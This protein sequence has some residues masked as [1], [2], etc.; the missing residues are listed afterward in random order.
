MTQ[1][2]TA[3]IELRDLIL[4]TRIGTYGANDTVPDQHLLSMTLWVDQNFILIKE[5]QMKYVFDY[6]PLIRDIDQVAQDGHYETQER[7]ITRI[8]ECCA[9]YPLIKSLEISL[10]KSPVLNQSGSLGIKLF[11]DSD[12][13]GQLKQK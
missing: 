6:D 4:Q 7:L 3:T 13:L 2:T 9:N 11:V 1:K 10:R 12:T 8:V 5:D